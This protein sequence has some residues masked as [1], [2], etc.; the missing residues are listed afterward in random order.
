MTIEERNQLIEDN[1]KLAGFAARAYRNILPFAELEELYSIACLVMVEATKT[2]KP[3]MGTYSNY[4]MNCV[5]CRYLNIKRIDNTQRRKVASPVLS[6]DHTYVGE[7]AE[8]E[9]YNAV[10]APEA[11]IDGEIDQRHMIEQ[12][13]MRLK[14]VEADIIQQHF[15]DDIGYDSI[16][17]AYGFSHQRAQQIAKQGLAKMACAGY[18]DSEYA[19]GRVKRHRA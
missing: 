9:L 6:L 12:M 1:I 8:N 2:Y 11:D 17:K 13:L 3:D 7:Y 4:I 16:A 5:M 15:V 14:P 19:Q 10:A 18:H